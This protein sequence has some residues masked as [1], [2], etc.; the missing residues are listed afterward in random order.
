MT[1]EMKLAVKNV[2]SYAW[3][4][5]VPQIISRVCHDSLSV[6]SVLS[7]LLQKMLKLY[8]SQCVW[9]AMGVLRAQQR[10]QAKE[11][12][13]V[14]F[15]SAMDGRDTE[16]RALSQ[17]Y[18]CTLSF[19][20]FV[21]AL[22]N[23]K[24]PDGESEIR[25]GSV[26]SLKHLYAE[27]QREGSSSVMVPTERFLRGT[28]PLDGRVDASWKPFGDLVTVSSV[29]DQ[30]QVLHSL[31]SPKV[32][33][34][35]GSDGQRYR[36]LAKP[37][38]DL[39][40]DS[41]VMEVNT[42]VNKLLYRNVEAR[43]RQLGIKT[44]AVIP[45]DELTGLIE[46]VPNLIGYRF[47][48]GS[49]TD[50]KK[51]TAA[52]DFFKR[53]DTMKPRDRYLQTMNMFPLCF[54]QWFANLFPEPMA[55]QEA[56]MRYTR[57][58][59]VMS[60]VG[61]MIGLGDRHGE[62]ILLDQTTGHVVHVDFNAVFGKGEAFTVPERVPFRLTANMVDAM[63]V[64]GIEGAFRRVCEITLGVLRSN[65]EMV[66]SVLETFL[67]DPLLEFHPR[68]AHPSE[69]KSRRSHAD[70]SKEPVNAFAKGIINKVEMKLRGRVVESL[71]NTS[72]SAASSKSAGKQAQKVDYTISRAISLSV[73]GQV[74]HLIKEAIEP[75]NLGAMYYG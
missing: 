36:F 26:S 75:E 72:R 59:A 3:L 34:F 43:R 20:H 30:V 1:D 47:A 60:M 46:W 35:V 66:V 56:R 27:F 58:C 13:L 71:Y 64:T 7:S 19:A 29:L 2:P 51:H 67:H 54:Y 65:C 9:M 61:A 17:I 57:S 52:R 73:E 31:Q 18:E 63:G 24:V 16:A 62:N 48:V 68:A 23:F 42:L 69:S 12:M 49:C 21:S 6:Q 15:K 41:R 55:W 38:D 39:R 37:K 45:V 25:L 44:Y 4:N 33:T 28:L 53:S 74:E 22:C 50:H 32:V 40:K 11:K 5:A 14:I 70:E 10:D 8:P